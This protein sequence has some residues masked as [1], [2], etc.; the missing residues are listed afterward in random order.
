MSATHSGVVATSET[1]AATVVKLS[2][3]DPGGEVD[4][5]RS[6]PEV[7][8]RVARR[9]GVRRSARTVIG[10]STSEAIA[11]RQAATTTPGRL[12]QRMNTAAT[13]IASTAT[14]RTVATRAAARA[15]SRRLSRAGRA[16]PAQ[17][18][19]PRRSSAAADGATAPKAPT[20][21]ATSA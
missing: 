7:G 6:P 8:Q 19:Q 1:E 10:S 3:R 13:L 18:P 15:R 9:S 14:A 17:A 21:V 2:E 16:G 20:S 12:R 5:S 11:M 4:P